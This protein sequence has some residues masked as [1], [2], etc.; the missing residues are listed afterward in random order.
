MMKYTG[1][2][3]KMAEEFRKEGCDDATIEKFIRREMEDDE[4]QKGDGTTDIAALK[5]WKEYPE[6]AKQ[7]WLHNA[8]CSKCG[9]TSFKSGYNL[10]IDKVGVVI[11]GYC[12]KCGSKIARVC[13]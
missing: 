2:Y 8:F 6:N 7:M 3:K 11:Q 9:N 4:F 13:D 10:R 5:L 12:A 1:K